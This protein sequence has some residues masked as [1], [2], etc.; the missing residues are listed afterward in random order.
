MKVFPHI[1]QG[2]GYIQLS[3][4]PIN[5]NLKLKNWISENSL[6][7][8]RSNN[9]VIEYC[10]QYSEYEYWFDFFNDEKSKELEFDF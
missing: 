6:I 9:G 2:A 7:K 8:L 10:I 4:L 3:R 1:N 5:Q